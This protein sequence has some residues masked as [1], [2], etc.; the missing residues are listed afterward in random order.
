MLEDT[1]PTGLGMRVRDAR[2][3]LGLTL[4]E[5]SAQSG[6]SPSALSKIE[7]D[8]LSPTY[9]N[10]VRLARGLNISVT[11]LFGAVGD[12]ELEKERFS[13]MRRDEGD[14]I[15]TGNYE[16]YYL[17]M[18]LPTR[19]MTP[20]IVVHNARTL[21]EFGPMVSHPGEEFTFVLSGMI[22]V[23]AGGH[24]PTLLSPGDS[25]YFDSNMPHAYLAASRMPCC[26]LSVCSDLDQDELRQLLAR[27][28]PA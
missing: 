8:K 19:A 25:V 28:Q 7:R 27:H 10:I 21:A 14:E 9:A 22:E 23:H 17:H 15:N 18:G 2:K 12:G 4:I 16:H 3:K 26:T 1:E 24:A 20:L 6:I 13:V 5:L 11:E